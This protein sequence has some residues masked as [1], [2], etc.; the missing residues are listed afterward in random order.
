MFSIIPQFYLKEDYPPFQKLRLI[1]RVRIFTVFWIRFRSNVYLRDIIKTL[2]VVVENSVYGYCEAWAWIHD[3][4]HCQLLKWPFKTLFKSGLMNR[5]K[6]FRKQIQQLLQRFK[7][8]H[9]KNINMQEY[10]FQ[11]FDLYTYTLASYS[12]IKICENET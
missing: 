6:F 9:R 11:N 3:R 4:H 1:H 5:I 12:A 10:V 8:F 2:L 7:T